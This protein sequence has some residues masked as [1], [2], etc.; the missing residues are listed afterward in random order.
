[1]EFDEMKKIWDAQN[2]EPLYAMDEKTLQKRIQRKK[3]SV[4]TS[5][6]EWILIISY[7]GAASLLVGYYSF[8]PGSNIF[9]SLE[10][11]WMFGVVVYIVISH[12]RRIKASRWFDRS[13]HGDLYHSIYL[14]SCQMH[15][16]QVTR[17]NLLPM[18]VI[19]IFSG[20]AAGKLFFV[21]AVV[22]VLY[23]LTFYAAGKGIRANKRRK[24]KLQVLIGKLETGK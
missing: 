24:Q 5:I 1:M 23:S 22:L 4:L 10:A 18:G 19:M 15:I 8:K 9:L 7:L 13:V 21:S 6:S 14:I 12:I 17:W 20:W 11:A 16:S 3:H 2:N